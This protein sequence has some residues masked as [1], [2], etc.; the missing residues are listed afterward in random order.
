M[1]KGQFRNCRGQS[2]V[3]IGALLAVFVV[4]LLGM[5]AFEAGRVEIAREQ[6]MGACDAAA[7]SSVCTLAGSDIAQ[8]TDAHTN[9]KNLAMNSFKQNYVM[10]HQLTNATEGAKDADPGPNEAVV[11]IE[12]LDPHNNYQP[13]AMGDPKGKVVRVYGSYGVVPVFAKFLGIEKAVVRAS[14]SGGIP[15]LDLILCFD[16]SASMDDQTPVTFVKR[17]WDSGV[18]KIVYTITTSNGSPAGPLAQGPIATVVGAPASGTAVNALAPQ[19]LDC[20]NYV[21]THPLNFSESEDAKGL[22]GATN[23]GSPPGNY[24]PGTAALGGAHTYTDLV[25]NLDG[26]NQFQGFS[27]DGYD[28]PDVAT[29]VEAARGNLENET[30][31]QSSKANLS[32]PNISPRSGYQAKYLECA[33]PKQQPIEDG[34][35]AAQYFL[36]IMNINTDAHFGVV[37]FSTIAGTSPNYSMPGANVSNQYPAGGTVDVVVPTVAL[38]KNQ[39]NFQ[40]V[41]SAVGKVEAFGATNIGDAVD[42]AVRHLKSQTRPTSKQVIVLFTDGMPTQGG[43]LSGDPMSNAR[44]AAVKAHEAGIPVFTLGLAQ[45]SEIIPFETE[46]LNDTNDDH[47]SGGIAAISG[48]GARFYLVTDSSKLRATFENI[49]RQLVQ[50]IDTEVED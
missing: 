23:T 47:S 19:N 35:Y 43:P 31:F 42:T 38:D 28:F 2:L 15:Q 44:Q 21:T 1:V 14:S 50:L 46:I 8:A 30:V 16:V 13:V 20:G 11:Y 7:L 18:N 33:R 25:V 39:S 10:G 5:F 4:G 36:N 45:N 17:R 29:L 9:A 27:K 26:N 12:I 34:R 49:A 40:D 6:L 41:M 32:L 24:P 22:R 37:S 3:I 48:N